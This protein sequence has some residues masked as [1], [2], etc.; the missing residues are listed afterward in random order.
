MLSLRACARA[1]PRVARAGLAPSTALRM[2]STLAA[3]SSRKHSPLAAAVAARTRVSVAAFSSAAVRR[4]P[5]NSEVDEELSA[6]LAS[7]IEFE[8]EIRENEPEATSV[9]DFLESGL[10]EIEDV[11]GREEVVLRRTYGNEK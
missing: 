1:V 9:K 2:R 5:A 4:T 7:E 8:T 6:K 10:F 3:S 11:P